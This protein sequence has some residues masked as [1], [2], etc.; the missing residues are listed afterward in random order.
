MQSEPTANVE[1]GEATLDLTR[2]I[3]E[4]G[5]P[6][7]P[8]LP[9]VA[10]RVM[11]LAQDDRSDLRELATVIRHDPAFAAQLLRAASSPV[12]GGRGP[13]ASLQQAL[14]RLGMTQL[15]QIA[16]MIVM[17][18][19]L[20][21][22]RGHEKTLGE[23]FRLATVSALFAQEIARLRR[24]NVEE[25]FLAGLLHDIGEPVVLRLGVDHLE[26]A[27]RVARP[28]SPEA[29]R[30]ALARS[31]AELHTEVGAQ[32]IASWELPA[33]LAETARSHHAADRACGNLVRTVMLADALAACAFGRCAC[34]EAAED[35][36]EPEVPDEVLGALGVYPDHVATLVARGRALVA[37]TGTL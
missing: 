27:P 22:V 18:S 24:S 21:A 35:R 2:A 30:E 10:Q 7:L 19:D 5:A 34:P 28:A 13:V 23:L 8:V 6:E 20:Y 17:R 11:T 14:A 25:A 12:Y 3:R 31:M 1:G 32:V 36:H 16:L 9:R 29:V 4:G 33:A 26:R 15:R 37:A